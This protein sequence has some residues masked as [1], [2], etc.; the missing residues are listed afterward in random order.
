MQEK[1]YDFRKRHWTVHRPNMRQADRTRQ[2]NEL[3]IDNSWKL[4]GCCGEVTQNALKDFQDYLWVSMGLSVGRTAENGAKTIWFTVDET[5]ERGFV[6]VAEENSLL[7]K[8]AADKEA[9]RASVYLEDIMNLEGAPVVPLGET[10]RKPL[11]DRKEVHSGTG[12]D[13][14]PDEELLAVV[15]AGYDTIAIM[16]KDI[17]VTAAGHC[18]INDIIQRA[19]RFGI[20]SFLFNYIQTPVHPDE[21]GAQEIFDKAYGNLFRHYP[22]AVGIGMTGEALEFPSKDPHTTGKPRKQS[23]VDGIPDVRPSVGW[24][25]CYDY[26]AYLACIEKAVHKANPNAE[27]CYSTYN[28]GYRSKEERQQFL[29]KLPEG[30]TVSV[31]F[32]I[33][34]KR[35]LEGLRTPVMDYTISADEPGEYFVTECENCKRLGIPVR[36]NVNITGIAWDFGCVPWVPAPDKLLRRLRLLHDNQDKWNLKSFYATHHYGYWNSYAADLGKWTGW[37]GYEPDYEEL[38]R[39]IAVRDYGKDGAEY[40]LKAW[41]LW[42]KAMDHYIASNEDQYGPW[43]V[44][45][46]YPFVF[47]PSITRTMDRKEIKFPTAPHAHFGHGIIKTMY[48]PFENIDQAPGFLR[49][50]AEIRS[51]TKMEDYWQQGLAEAKKMPQSQYAELMVALGQFILCQVR[52]VINIKRWWMLNMKLQISQ[53]QEEALDI[54]AQLRELAHKE[55][56]NARDC[57]PAVETDSRIG[58]EP[59]M[60]Y[61]CDK[62]HLEWKLRYMEHTLR[63]LDVYKSIVENAY[64]KDV[65]A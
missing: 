38:L 5:L 29:E 27:V 30:Y 46:A 4:G 33:F 39:K 53:S 44:G 42:S 6:L 37:D 47:Q 17:D 8:L 40:A 13:E 65:N 58:W 62:W 61:V 1:N 7:V 9:F 52:T 16:V 48:Q 51:L 41:K 14:Y 23:I 50:P 64:A 22:D 56:D 60:E 15:H 11:F 32:E 59:S 31:C 20:G 18:N 49:Y 34:S 25:P 36:G 35:T 57:I 63:E 28:W 19:K 54:L 43:R 10:V 26:P 24:Y 45:A 12:I 55:M 2:D 3:L 21:P